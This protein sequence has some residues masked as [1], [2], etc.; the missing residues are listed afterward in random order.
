MLFFHSAYINIISFKKFVDFQ[1]AK[2]YHERLPLQQ[3]PL[4]N[5]K[6]VQRRT[7]Y[8]SGNVCEKANKNAVHLNNK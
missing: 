3:S 2:E 8:A 6:Q 1:E 4:A 5:G 7:E